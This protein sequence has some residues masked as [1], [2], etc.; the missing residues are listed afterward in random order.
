[1]MLNMDHAFRNKHPFQNVSDI[2]GENT[3][4]RENRIDDVVI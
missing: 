3:M 4:F 1:M 2:K